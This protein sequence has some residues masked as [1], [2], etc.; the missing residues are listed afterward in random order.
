MVKK[1]RFLCLLS[2]TMFPFTYK[3]KYEI[4][5]KAPSLLQTLFL[6]RIQKKFVVA[7]FKEEDQSVKIKIESFARL[8][9]VS[10]ATILLRSQE[11]ST[12]VWFEIEF[13]HSV[14]MSL[15]AGLF[16]IAFGLSAGT[17]DWRFYLIGLVGG[18]LYAQLFCLFAYLLFRSRLKSVLKDLKS[19]KAIQ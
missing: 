3:G 13:W 10:G 4:A 1:K 15:I 16:F 18:I 19:I 8:K 12:F 9:W 6:K 17:S 5:T 11:Q 14:T 7:S 2:C